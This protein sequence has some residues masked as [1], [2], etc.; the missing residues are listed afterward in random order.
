ME[1]GASSHN[2]RATRCS[3]EIQTIYQQH[4]YW[5]SETRSAILSSAVFRNLS[6]D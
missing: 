5:L 3:M 1:E 2:L 6:I 4:Q